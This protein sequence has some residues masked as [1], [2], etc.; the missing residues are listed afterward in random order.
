MPTV[1]FSSEKDAL[2]MKR[3]AAEQI[4][5]YSVPRRWLINDDTIT[6]NIYGEPGAPISSDD[7]ATSAPATRQFT[8]AG[9]NFN[10]AGVKPSD[11]LEIQTPA[12]NDGDNGKYQVN[13]VVSDIVLEITEDWPAGDLTSLVFILHFLKERYTEHDQL[14]PFQVKLEPT[15]KELDQWG[16]QE[17]RDARILMST[18]LCEDINLTPKIGDRFVYKYQGRDIHYEVKNLFGD[19]SLSDSGQPLWWL[20][21]AM[22][23]TNRL[24]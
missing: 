3:R 21:Y 24:P 19:G 14:V 2:Y 23:T 4:R 8:S 11:V 6:L 7:G 1:R 12:C 16:I 10:T 22:R 5:L 15:Q 17:K 20:G 13:Q 18:Q 9:S